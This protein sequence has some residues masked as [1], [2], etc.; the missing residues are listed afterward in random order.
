MCGITGIVGDGAGSH[1]NSIQKILAAMDHRGPDGNGIYNS[2]RNDCIMAGNRLAILDISKRASQ[3]MHSEDGRFTFVYNGEC[4]N[5]LEL[6]N[7]LEKE[8]VV[9]LSSGDTEV[10]FKWLVLKGKDGLKDINGMFSLALWDDKKKTLLLARDH[11]GQKPLYWLRFDNFFLFASEVRALL[12]S[13]L[14]ERKADRSSIQSF[15]AYGTIAWPN[16]IIENIRQLPP[17]AFFIV[18]GDMNFKESIYRPVNEN[19][20]A[21]ESG[22][23]RSIFLETVKRHLI[24]DVPVA[25]FLS[26]GIDSSS[27]T[28]AVNILDMNESVTNVSLTY[29]DDPEFSE[30]KYS[31]MVSDMTG[32]KYMEFPVSGN[33]FGKLVPK[34]LDALDQPSMDGVNVW[35]ISH[36]AGQSGFKVALS[37]LGG[38]ELFG[39]YPTFYD[40]H[41]FMKWRNLLQ[42]LK[43]I[44][45]LFLRHN[46]RYHRV[47][48]FFDLLEN[49]R[50]ILK[51]YLIRR[52]VLSLELRKSVYSVNMHDS[53]TLLSDDTLSFLK[54]LTEGHTVLN[55]IRLL[56]LYFYMSQVLLKDA[57]IMGMAHSIEIRAPF[58]DSAFLERALRVDIPLR[59]NPLKSAWTGEIGDWLPKEIVRRKKQGFQLPLAGYLKG[60]LYH[61]VE[62]NLYYLFENYSCFNRREIVTLWQRFLI[63]PKK[64]GWNRIWALFVLGYYLRKHNLR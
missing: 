37:G 50:D 6:R 41:W 57:D 42:P 33:E 3:P 26:G 46:P 2:S 62:E 52:E 11:L 44:K 56:E 38:D 21:P 24:S 51:L 20:S 40:I 47:E 23:L 34:A 36:A 53:T 1:V 4:Y 39:G 28:A 29:P 31:G 60:E 27:L 14:I 63:N 5:F 58:L 8:G 18:T 45:P 15:L 55:A 10:V 64:R 54:R 17:G 9:F 30:H 22:E 49:Q 13:G 61:L 19:R 25:L 7:S 16:T 43:S 32:C 35:L 48:K 12:A 59:S